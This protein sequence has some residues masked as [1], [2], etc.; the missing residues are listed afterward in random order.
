MLL[1]PV[2]DLHVI[3][4]GKVGRSQNDTLGRIQG[5][6]ARNTDG[7]RFLIHNA[8]CQRNEPIHHFFRCHR[9]IRVDFFLFQQFNLPV[10]PP[11]GNNGTFGSA[12]IKS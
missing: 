6:T 2:H 12:N 11:G 4:A 7:F 1:D 10:F 5:T 3:P 9:Q 8:V